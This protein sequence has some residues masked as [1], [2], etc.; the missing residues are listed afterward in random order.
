MRIFVCIIAIISVYVRLFELLMLKENLKVY[1]I[2]PE[3]K[4]TCQIENCDTFMFNDSLHF[5]LFTGH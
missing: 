2:T 1:L 5:Q 4:K 3:K